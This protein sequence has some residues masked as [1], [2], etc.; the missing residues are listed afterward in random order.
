MR[1]ERGV[2]MLE[3]FMAQRRREESPREFV[4]TLLW[5]AITSHLGGQAHCQDYCSHCHFYDE[6]IRQHR[7]SAV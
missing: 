5:M 4:T 3:M 1:E 2:K 6:A 7:Q